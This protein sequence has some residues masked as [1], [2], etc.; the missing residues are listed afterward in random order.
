MIKEVSGY[1]DLVEYIFKA[2]GIV[3]ADFHNTYTQ[4]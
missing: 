4:L 1:Q 3:I 2:G